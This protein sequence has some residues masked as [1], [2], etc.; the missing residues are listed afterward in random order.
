MRT[1]AKG[2]DGAY[3]DTKPSQKTVI[4]RWKELTGAVRRKYGLI[5][6]EITLSVTNVRYE[7]YS[8]GASL[9]LT[10]R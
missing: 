9:T 1:I 8:A 4:Q 2:I 7:Q 6:P 3:G 5:P 10:R